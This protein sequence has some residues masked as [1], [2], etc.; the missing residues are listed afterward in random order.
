MWASGTAPSRSRPRSLC[1]LRLNRPD[2]Q[3]ATSHS[4][5]TLLGAP[6]AMAV[7]SPRGLQLRPAGPIQGSA[8][9]IFTASA[10]QKNPA[11][12]RAQGFDFSAF[13]YATVAPCARPA[14]SVARISA[15]FVQFVPRYEHTNWRSPD[16]LWLPGKDLPCGRLMTVGRMVTE[17]SLLLVA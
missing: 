6:P 15:G 2:C 12:F 3:N 10:Q 13:F 5:G 1:S 16:R 8:G 4:R 7:A 11:T 9:K 14:C 17:G